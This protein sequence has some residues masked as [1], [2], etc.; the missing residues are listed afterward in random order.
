MRLLVFLPIISLRLP[1][2]SRFYPLRQF[3]YLPDTFRSPGFPERGSAGGVFSEPKV[4]GGG[5]VVS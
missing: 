1:S 2:V 4:C 5:L 3:P